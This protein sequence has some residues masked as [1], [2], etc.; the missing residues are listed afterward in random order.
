[1]SKIPNINLH[2]YLVRNT[3]NRGGGRTDNVH[4][5]KYRKTSAINE[6][7]KFKPVVS[8]KIIMAED[9][10]ERRRGAN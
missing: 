3:L 6:W 2:G 10:E 5:S 9:D 4:G 7:S 1:M 8:P